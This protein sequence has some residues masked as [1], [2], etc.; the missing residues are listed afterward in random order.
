M[1]FGITI[2]S[3]DMRFCAAALSHIGIHTILS[4][5]LFALQCAYSSSHRSPICCANRRMN[6]SRF[7]LRSLRKSGAI[8]EALQCTD[9]PAAEAQRSRKSESFDAFFDAEITMEDATHYSYLFLSS[10]E[11]ENMDFDVGNAQLKITNDRVVAIDSDDTNYI[12]KHI[13]EFTEILY[14]DEIDEVL[15]VYEEQ[16]N[17]LLIS[18]GDYERKCI[19]TFLQHYN[20]GE[21]SIYS[22]KDDI[23]KRV[24]N[25]VNTI[26]ENIDFGAFPKD[27]SLLFKYQNKEQK[28]VFFD[29]KENYSLIYMILKRNKSQNSNLWKFLDDIIMNSILVL[30]SFCK[31]KL[32]IKVLS[33][34]C[35]F[36]KSVIVPKNTQREKI[37]VQ[38]EEFKN[39]SNEKT[40]GKKEKII[41]ETEQLKQKLTLINEQYQQ[42][43]DKYLNGKRKIIMLNEMMVKNMEQKENLIK[44]K[45]EIKNFILENID[46]TKQLKDYYFNCSNQIKDIK[47]TFSNLSNFINNKNMYQKELQI[48]EKKFLNIK[49]EGVKFCLK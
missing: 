38:I 10:E 13:F 21:Y 11:D 24:P 48:F 15:K 14:D 42:L 39:E 9:L 6:R 22:F 43:K 44:E 23:I 2:L 29:A 34:I 41:N 45:I 7:P 25:H 37:R 49:N 17:L 1:R 30:M 5:N 27:K 35:Q 46:F 26:F 36:K 32:S 18:F 3:V 12:I 20:Y 31:V 4:P 33:C 19:G 16:K 40:K 28:I 8:N 47:K